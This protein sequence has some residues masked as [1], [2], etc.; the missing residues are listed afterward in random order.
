MDVDRSWRLF[1]DG[2]LI[3]TPPED[4]IGVTNPATGE[5]V[6]TA[7]VASR[8]D[9]DRAVAAASEAFE[10]WRWQSPKERGA[11]LYE[12]ADIIETHR[13]ELIE[14]ETLENGKPLDQSATDVDKAAS[15]FRFYA[16]AADK[17]HGATVRDAPSTVSKKVFEPYGVIGIIIPWNWPP[18]HTA[19]FIAIALATGNTAVVKTAPETPLSS[20]RL[21]ELL[22]DVFPPGTFNVLTGGTDPGVAVTEHEN[23]DMLAF[24]GNDQTGEKILAAAAERIVPTMLELGGKNPELVFPDADFEKAVSGTVANS[25]YNSGQACAD[26]ERLFVHRDIYDE[27]LN[28]VATEV[29]NLVVGDG[30]DESTQV[31]PLSSEK[32]YEKVTGYLDLVADADGRVVTQAEVPADPSLADGYWVPPTVIDGLDL[33]NRAASEEIFGPVVAVFPFETEEEVLAKA[34]DIDYGLTAVVWT[35]DLNRAHRLASQL[36][37]GTVAINNRT[38]GAHGLPFGGYKRSG[39]GRKSDFEET[40][41]AFTQVKSIHMDLTDDHFSI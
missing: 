14:L 25:F 2:D 38:S 5:Q 37:A 30:R 4:C 1:V 16:G 15:Y 18:L 28:A 20:L 3:D 12:A 27:F 23:V 39:I 36:E 13:E 8:S 7:P 22:A 26:T 24:T 19:Q 32:Q 9:V 10:E 40:M 17:F 31:G 6:A 41:R 34:N 11:K 21:A 29:E 35:E 33:D